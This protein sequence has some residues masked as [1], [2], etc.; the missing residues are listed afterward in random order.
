MAEVKYRR[1]DNKYFEKSKEL[2]TIKEI[3]KAFGQNNRNPKN[4]FSQIAKGSR[5]SISSQESRQARALQYPIVLKVMTETETK[6]YH[7]KRLYELSL[8]SI[9]SHENKMVDNKWV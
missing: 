1:H 8:E 2:F 9:A 4:Y 6:E 3:D 7:L 5:Q